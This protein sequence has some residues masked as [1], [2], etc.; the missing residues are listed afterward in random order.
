M[1]G[2]ISNENGSN[3]YVE[4]YSCNGSQRVY[5]PILL[6]INNVLVCLFCV[7]IHLF[8]IIERYMQYLSLRAVDSFKKNY[9]LFYFKR[10]NVKNC[11][12]FEKYR[13]YTNYWYLR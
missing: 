8:Q 13:A 5:I 4:I 7:L 9:H 12:L 2:L 6:F 10:N 3:L 1:L 11:Y